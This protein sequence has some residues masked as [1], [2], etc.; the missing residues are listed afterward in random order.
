MTDSARARARTYGS[1]G[2][3]RRA[4]AHLLSEEPLRAGGSKPEVVRAVPW[5][6]PDIQC[7]QSLTAETS[8][9]TAYQCGRE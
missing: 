4:G 8:P 3:N 7:R 6:Y 5:A 9:R 2:V 1:A